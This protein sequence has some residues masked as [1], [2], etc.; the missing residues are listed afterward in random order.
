MA[1]KDYKSTLKLPKTD[2]PMKANLPKR[3]PEMLAHWDAI[4]LYGRLMEERKGA[5]AWILHDGPPYAN[6]RVHLG[7]ALNKILKDF[8]VRSRAMMGFRTPYVPGWDCHGMPIEHR[9]SRELGPRA[10]TIPK[11]ELRKL[12]RAEADKWIDIQRE[13]FRR[14]GAI[15]DWFDPYLTMKPEYDA[16]EVRGLRK[17][18][19]SGYVYRGLRPVHWCFDCRTA[20]AEAEV[21]YREHASPSIY[22]AFQIAVNP[23]GAGA[24]AADPKDAAALDEASRAGK[25]CAVIW[26]TT[27][28]TLPANLGISLN[29]A[30]DYVALETA[31][32]WYIVGAKLA[33]AVEKECSLAVTRRVALDRE[34]IR[35]LDGRDIFRHPFLPRTVKL[36]YGDH[37]TAD[38]GTGLVHTAPGHGYEDFVIGKQYGLKPFTPVDDAG[39][40]T[41]DGGEWAGRNV[42]EC[43]DAIVAK[44]RETGALLGAKKLAHSYPHCWRCK[45]PLI[46]RATEQWFLNIDHEGLRERVI[47]AIDRVKWVPGW[48]QDRIRNM[49]ETRPDWCLSRQRAWGVPIPALKCEKCGKV[50]LDLA[51]MDRAAEI[52]A[53]EGS[54]AWYSRP[55]SDFAAPALKC[56]SCGGT[57]FA[58][59]EDVLDVW[60]DSGSSQAAVLRERKELAWPADAYL[61]AVEQARGWFGSSLVCAV[62]DQKAAPFKSVISHGL[63][64]DEKGRKMSKSLGNSEDAIDVVNRIGADIL[65]LV[66]AS[67]DYTSEI[68]LGPTIYAAVSES[69]R[70]I[71]NTCRFMLGNLSDFDPV[72]DAVPFDRMLEFDRFILARTDKLNSDVRSAYEKFDFQAAYTAIL[73]FM[74]IDLS[75]LYIDVARDRLYCDAEASLNRRSAQTA[76]FR[77][78]DAILRML[79]PLIP[80]TA[81]EVYSHLPGPREQ[82]LHLLAM[83]ENPGWRDEKL[84]ARWEELLKLRSH[85]LKTLEE[86]RAAQIIGAP[87]DAEVD[88][89]FDNEKVVSHLLALK[90]QLRQLFIVSTVEIGELK[91]KAHLMSLAEEMEPPIKAITHPFD[92][93]GTSTSVVQ[94]RHAPGVK[95]Q[96]CWCYFD[97]GGHPE[98][99]PRCGEVVKA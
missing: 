65:R 18:T 97:D 56:A 61:E 26:T 98:L 13:D 51:T 68:A 84:E 52:F 27:P 19:E 48:S 78:L 14:L 76:L 75:A 64:V 36:M 91:G 47:D 46:F 74:V 93:P 95:C 35:K 3:E 6:G 79:A 34:A 94:A 54:D 37:V 4:D 24:L 92:W 20:L 10:R 7:T 45:N 89:L 82:S 38:T 33:E 21:E 90:E 99:C 71:R 2:F 9:V 63:T 31:A 55:A 12:C 96:R 15:G 8:V 32:G 62:A 16:A 41:A 67:L 49:T 58:K 30:F 23:A 57:V 66:Y 72:R 22:V 39:K 70:K 5:P 80:F 53:R 17:L 28:W 59:E 50:V 11:L 43:N 60:F 1:E 86:A 85:V 83:H 29:P 73:S 44:L 40:F 69:Y 42:F 81:D 88:L 77:M 25:L 87:L